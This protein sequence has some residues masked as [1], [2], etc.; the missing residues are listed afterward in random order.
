MSTIFNWPHVTVVFGIFMCDDDTTCSWDCTTMKDD[1]I[2][3]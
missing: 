2:I 3:E 1:V